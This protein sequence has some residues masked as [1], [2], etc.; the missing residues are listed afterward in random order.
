MFHFSPTTMERAGLPSSA[1]MSIPPFVVIASN[2]INQ[3][4]LQ[5]CGAWLASGR[6]PA[7]WLLWLAAC[8]AACF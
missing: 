8:T 1:A 2:D 7:T 4:A 3:A 5:V 6:A